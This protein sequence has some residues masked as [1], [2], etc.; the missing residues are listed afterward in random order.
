MYRLKVLNI[1]LSDF[2]FQVLNIGILPEINV[3]YFSKSNVK[4]QS[5]FKLKN[6]DIS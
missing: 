2:G 3:G 1:S 6:Y 5:Y 4:N